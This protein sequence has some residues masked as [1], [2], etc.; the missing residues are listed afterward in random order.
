MK[1][2]KPSFKKLLLFRQFA[3]S[4]TGVCAVHIEKVWRPFV[5]A[6]V[7]APCLINFSTAYGSEESSKFLVS[8]PVLKVNAFNGFSVPGAGTQKSLTQGVPIKSGSDF[9]IDSTSEFSGGVPPPGVQSDSSSYQ[10]NK[11]K[12]NIDY[13][14][15]IIQDLALAF[16]FWVIFFSDKD[17]LDP[18][19]FEKKHN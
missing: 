15:E 8:P 13:I 10:R 3:T 16:L 5:F 2:F 9:R 12:Q 4:R 7:L 1:F 11:L 14:F 19:S 18:Y 6:S 17:F